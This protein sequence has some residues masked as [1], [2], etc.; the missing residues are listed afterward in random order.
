MAYHYEDDMMLYNQCVQMFNAACKINYLK[1][2]WYIQCQEK[3]IADKME[4]VMNF[5]PDFHDATRDS[6]GATMI[7]TLT[8]FLEGFNSDEETGKFVK[9]CKKI[10]NLIEK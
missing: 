9:W 4:K 8:N 6:T 2:E 10:I 5:I 7:Y 1:N 3:K